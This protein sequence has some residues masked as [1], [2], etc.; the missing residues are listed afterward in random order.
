MKKLRDEAGRLGDESNQ[1]HGDR[2]LGYFKL[3]NPL[4]NIS[5][6]IESLEEAQSAKA[7]EDKKTAVESVIEMTNKRTSAGRRG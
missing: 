6:E 2:N 4:R 1:L 3:E 5:G 7:E